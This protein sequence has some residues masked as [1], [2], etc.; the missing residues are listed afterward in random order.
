MPADR[1]SDF[2]ILSGNGSRLAFLDSAASSQKPQVVLDAMTEAYATYYANVH[3]GA[4]SFSL[5]STEAYEGARST[6]AGFIGAD[7]SEVVFTRGTTTAL[8][9]LASS[10]GVAHLSPGDRILLSQMEHH[11]NL[12]PWQMVAK[13]TGAELLFAPLDG[14]YELDLE[15]TRQMVDE[16]VK[17]ISITGMSNVLGTI[18]P[19]TQLEAIAHSVGAVLI[20]DGAQLVAHTPIDVTALGA[21][22]LAFSSHKMLGPTGVGVLW[23][24]GALLDEME[25]FEGG[26]E[27]IDDVGLYESTW[28]KVPQKFEAGTP[29]FVEAIGLAAAVD[30]LAEIGMGVVRSEDMALTEYALAELDQIPNVTVYGPRNLEHRGGVISFTMGDVHPHDLA[31]ILD[32]HGVSVRAGHHCARPL[33]DHLGVPATARASF[34]VYSDESDVDQLTTA[35]HRAGELFGL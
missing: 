28:A 1:R 24:R 2:P 12:V 9:M 35:L 10:W 25:P 3:R 8:N 19:I 18:T 4:Y 33:M 34:S 30:Y 17:I 7:P 23:G 15:A 16:R 20:I 27:M 32:Q 26:G 14:H 11:S 21:D 22:F 13:R 31:T 5:Q 29:P 6:V